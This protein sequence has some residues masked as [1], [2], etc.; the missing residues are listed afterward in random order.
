MDIWELKK[1]KIVLKKMIIIIRQAM[2]TPFNTFTP[3]PQRRHL[4]F[5]GR[6]SPLPHAGHIAGQPESLSCP[7][8]HT[9]HGGRRA[10]RIAL[11][12]RGRGGWWP[13]TGSGNPFPGAGPVGRWRGVAVGGRGWPGR[14]SSVCVSPAGRNECRTRIVLHQS[15]GRFNTKLFNTG[16]VAGSG[17]E[18]S[19]LPAPASPPPPLSALL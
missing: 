15:P 8:V 3:Q 14:G 6:L 1:I 4:A 11:P 18:P 13:R 16:P 19:L 2:G 5:A 17:E 9:R 10:A 12:L 7:R